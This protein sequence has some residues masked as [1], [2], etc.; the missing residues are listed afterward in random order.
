MT[1]GIDAETHAAI[2]ELPRGRRDP[3]R[4]DP[5][6]EAAAPA[7]HRRGPAVGRLPAEP[8]ADAD[9]PRRARSCCAASPT[10]TSTSPRRRAARTSPTRTR[11]SSTLLAGQAAVAIE[12]ARLYEASTRWSRQL[13]SLN[14]VG[15]ALATETDLDRLLDLVARRCASCSSARLVAVLLPAG[16][17]RAAVR[18]GAGEG[19]AEPARP[20]ACAQRVEERPRARA[21]AQRAGRLGARRPR[22]G[23]ARS[24]R[25]LGARTGLWVPLVARGRAIGVLDV[26]DK[27]GAAT[28]GSPTTTSGWRRRSRPARPSPSTS[29]SGSRATRSAARGRGAG[30]GAPPARARAARRDRP[31]ADLDPARP[32]R[33]SRTRCR[34]TASAR[35]R[36]RARARRAAR[37]RTSAGSRSSCGRRRS[38][39]SGSSPRS[40]GSP[41]TFARADRP[42]RRLRAALGDERLPRGGRDRAVP[43]RA[44]VADERR[45]A[46]DARA[47]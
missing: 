18:R 17:G 19:A 12:N 1:H 39:T 21:G 47:A 42:R 43:D 6:G 36:R 27:L 9:V 24:T 15:N 11:S 13:E 35:G 29:P 25:R 46:R 16:A 5:R 32:A 33:R 28:P 31:G 37:S 14:E 38:T 4:A 3:R 20:D 8:S 34:T 30:A 40:S 22:G 41:T 2:G 26:H 23:P 10:A 44:G 45:Q 7:R